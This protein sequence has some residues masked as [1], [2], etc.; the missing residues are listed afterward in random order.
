MTFIR[1][2]LE[3]VKEKISLFKSEIAILSFCEKA[4]E[5]NREVIMTVNGTR[6]LNILKLCEEEETELIEY[7]KSCKDR[8]YLL[9]FA[10]ISYK[11]ANKENGYKNENTEE[12]LEHS[13]YEWKYSK[14]ETDIAQ[15]DCGGH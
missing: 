5:E 2:E 12:M 9:K 13:F 1:N 6:A 4:I 11:P 8:Y 14:R 15:N 3:K 10:F 7:L